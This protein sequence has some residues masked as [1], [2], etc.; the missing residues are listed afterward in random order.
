MSLTFCD[1]LVIR[2]AP[3]SLGKFSRLSFHYVENNDFFHLNSYRINVKKSHTDLLKIG[4]PEVVF[5]TLKNKFIK[6]KAYVTEFLSEA[7]IIYTRNRCFLTIITP[8]HS[9]LTLTFLDMFSIPF[10]HHQDFFGTYLRY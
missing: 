5:E 8:S 9:I 10:H 6:Q 7:L 2:H 3:R 1:C 4:A